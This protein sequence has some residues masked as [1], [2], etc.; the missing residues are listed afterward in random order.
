MLGVKPPHFESIE[1]PR[2][3]LR[4]MRVEDIPAFLAYRNDPDVARYQSWDATSEQQALRLVAELERLEPGMVNEWFQFAIARREDGALLGDFGL[5]TTPDTPIQGMVGYTLSRAHQRRGYA[6]EA[7]GAL[8]DYAFGPLAMHRVT[9]TVDPRNGPSIALL[10]RLGLRREGY[11]L[12]NA[13]IKGEW[14]DEYLYA[15]LASEWR[16]KQTP[17]L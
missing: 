5:L 7:V 14:C 3:C 11:F 16:A 4:R 13:Y 12:C 6:T 10:E 9:A 1:T 17:A 2:L 8:L 15:V